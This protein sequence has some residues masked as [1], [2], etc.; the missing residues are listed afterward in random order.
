MKTLLSLAL[1]LALSFGCVAAQAVDYSGMT[2]E[3]LQTI[4]EE[5]TAELESRSAL[6]APAEERTLY[7]GRY[8]IGQDIEPGV[9]QLTCT[10]TE[11]DQYSSLY[12]N[13]GSAYDNLLEGDSSLGSLFGAL[14]GMMS[15]LSYVSVDV[16]GSYGDSLQH[17]ELK[18]G[19]SVQLTL[20]EGTALKIADGVCSLTRLK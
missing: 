5:V 18:N 12:G 14:G 1:V 11:G 9:W 4:L 3:E 8:I 15:E 16:L 13:L 7:T 6:R 20:R 10:Q 2:T 19:Q 17:A